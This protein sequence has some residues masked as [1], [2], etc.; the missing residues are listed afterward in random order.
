MV[1]IGLGL[2]ALTGSGGERSFGVEVWKFGRIL[3][4]EDLFLLCTTHKF[5]EYYININ[6]LFFS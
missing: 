6:I 4:L 1:S 2:I 5:E 3:I